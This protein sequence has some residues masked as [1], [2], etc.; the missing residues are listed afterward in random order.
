MWPIIGFTIGAA[1]RAAYLAPVWFVVAPF[2]IPSQALADLTV[3]MLK[4]A[5]YAPVDW[6][7]SD[8]L[9]QKV[10]LTNGQ[11]LKHDTESDRDETLSLGKAVLGDL[12][13]DGKKDG[14]VILYH[15]TGGSGTVAQVAAVIDANGQPR[16][17]ASRNLGD[18]TEIKS[19]DIQ[20]GGIVI[21]LENPRFFPSQK[22]T[23][24]YRLNGWKLRGP[25]PFK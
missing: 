7:T 10:K 25:E 9:E 15:N 5:D 18:R 22:H 6:G 21:T 14:A 12:N 2:A 13:G 11:Y 16:H 3:S 8:R 17:V 4:N 20:A 19:L 1:R 23:V 24:R